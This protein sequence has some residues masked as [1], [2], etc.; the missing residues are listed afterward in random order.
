MA[1]GRGM[2]HLAADYVHP[3]PHGGRCRVRIF[4]PDDPRYTAVVICTEPRGNPGQSVTNAA[5]RIAAVVIAAYK[6]QVPL[7]WIEHY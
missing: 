5:E 4:L 6:L 7:V 2:M 1:G 3:T